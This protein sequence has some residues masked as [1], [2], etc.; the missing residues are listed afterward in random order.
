MIYPIK[1]KLCRTKGINCKHVQIYP[2]DFVS[3]C[4]K[5][6]HKPGFFS[7]LI[8]RIMSELTFLGKKY[9][10]PG[11]K[12]LEKSLYLNNENHSCVVNALSIVENFVKRNKLILVGGIAIDFALRLKGDSLYP[13]DEL[14]D[15]DFFSPTHYL[16]AYE[17]AEELCQ[18][19][20]PLIS[21][22]NALHP[23]TM[24]VR[25]GGTAVADITYMPKEL[26][27][28]IPTLFFKGFK[29]VHPHYQMISQHRSLSFPYSGV[30]FVD[31][32]GRFLKD[33]S[34]YSLLLTYYPFEMPVITTLP[35]ILVKKAP[36]LPNTILTG[37]SAFIYW[38]TKY[39]IKS[40]FDTKFNTTKKEMS[41]SI[42][43]DVPITVYCCT[44]FAEYINKIKKYKKAKTID[45]YHE[46]I[47][48][49]FERAEIGD[50]TVIDLFNNKIVGYEIQQSLKTVDLQGVMLY[51]LTYWVIYK[52]KL[53]LSAYIICLDM[54]KKTIKDNPD[55]IQSPTLPT[56][57]EKNMF[58]IDYIGGSK[59]TMIKWAIKLGFDKD[60][61]IYPTL[62]PK[63]AYPELAN[64]CTIKGY[65]DAV[66][67]VSNKEDST[68]EAA[69]KPTRQL[70]PFEY[71]MSEIF[72]IGGKKTKKLLNRY[73]L[74]VDDKL[75]FILS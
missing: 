8:Y 71:E 9:K 14:A 40:I 13:D 38:H 46:L 53:A 30:P 36:L 35:K 11:S 61:I 68:T 47:D 50:I 37:W 74:L 69:K 52:S 51:M 6:T 72:D 58:G 33:M 22:I 75:S 48:Y 18:L 20:Y 56:I 41:F 60:K 34:R 24:R 66:S 43:V 45:L 21:S 5:M 73:K 28:K 19:E 2:H 70:N 42:N 3:F 55:I 65:N 62:Q 39:K 12:T 29:F 10:I 57:N 16:H 1:L 27:D 26:F 17:L 15:Y 4:H 25:I 23:T 64:K 67:D 31:N 63:N 7:L 54:I 49:I 59:L 32:V 44:D